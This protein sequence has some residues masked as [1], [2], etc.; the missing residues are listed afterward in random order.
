MGTMTITQAAL[1]RPQALASVRGIIY[2]SPLSTFENLS[3]RICHRA[4]SF[5]YYVFRQVIPFFTSLRTDTDFSSCFARTTHP[6][7]IPTELW[8]SHEEY[9][10]PKILELA[11][12]MPSHSNV[13]VRMFQRGTHSA[14][15]SYGPE[16]VEAAVTEFWQ[17]VRGTLPPP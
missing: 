12:V 6:V 3:E 10:T 1:T 4:G 17:N 8:L 11:S 9:K 14:Y 13:K 15:Y 7:A 5:C 16:E 2:E